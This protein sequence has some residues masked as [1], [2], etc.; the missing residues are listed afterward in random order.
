MTNNPTDVSTPEAKSPVSKV[1]RAVFSS[2]KLL[3]KLSKASLRSYRPPAIYRVS[4]KAATSPT[5]E[6]ASSPSPLQASDKEHSPDQA[7]M[8]PSVVDIADAMTP[9]LSN[10]PDLATPSPVSTHTTFLHTLVDAISEEPHKKSQNAPIKLP[11][12][13][14]LASMDST[15]VLAT[16]SNSSAA[17]SS[18]SNSHPY[19]SMSSPYSSPR[20]VNPYVAQQQQQH[21]YASNYGASV[22]AYGSGT[23]PGPYSSMDV[24]RSYFATHG[25]PMTT[26]PS[27]SPSSQSGYHPHPHQHPHHP[28][29][30]GDS[31]KRGRFGSSDGP[32]SSFG[33]GSTAA[34]TGYPGTRWYNPSMPSYT[35]AGMHASTTRHALPPL[36]IKSDSQP[37]FTGR[38]GHDDLAKAY[39]C[40]PPTATG[41]T[42]EMRRSMETKPVPGDHAMMPHIKQ[43]HDHV[44]PMA[45]AKSPMAKHKM[46]TKKHSDMDDSED[47]STNDSGSDDD[48][49][50]DHDHN[51]ESHHRGDDYSN[52]GER[53]S[54]LSSTRAITQTLKTHIGTSGKLELSHPGATVSLPQIPFNQHYAQRKAHKL[55]ERKRRREMKR[56]FDS[57]R[58]LL[59][60]VGGN[61]VDAKVKLSK[62]EILNG[63][64]D[65]IDALVRKQNM[66]LSKRGYLLPRLGL[67]GSPLPKPTSSSSSPAMAGSLSSSAAS[68][69]SL[70][71]TLPLS[72]ASSSI[73]ASPNIPTASTLM[74]QLGAQK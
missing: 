39:D 28:H 12:F 15:A 23:Q 43:A 13:S 65:V 69:P 41:S 30:A 56:L 49:D 63:A 1:T 26:P 59:P 57:L 58:G 40:Y 14:T 35:G 52:E 38:Y 31:S 51:E 24:K 47:D 33:Q 37:P 36:A 73:S 17:Q 62:W 20:Y 22:Y 34:S 27:S 4:S 60:A 19:P 64:V 54:P 18:V 45:N 44:V 48:D 21:A 11:S 61:N 3:S 32:S 55:A 70:H 67:G 5:V 10:G 25:S 6:T 66:L 68:L 74:M 72:M 29:G 16:K 53:A 2:S 50:D 7:N 8:F 9:S 46:M 42:L 71:A